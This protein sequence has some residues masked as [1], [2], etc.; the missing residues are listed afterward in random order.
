MFWFTAVSI[1]LLGLLAYGLFVEPRWLKVQRYR[2]SLHPHPSTWLRIAFLSDFHTGAGIPSS[3]WERIVLEVNALA[4]DAVILGGDFVVDRAVAIKEFLPFKK[5]NAPQGIYFVLGNHD[6]LERPQAIRTALIDMGFMD[7]T[8]RSI[9]LHREGKRVELHG[10]DDHWYGAPQPFTRES[11][12][13]PHILIAHEPD[14]M[15]DVK[16][17]ETDLVLA[18]HT[19]GRQVNVPFVSQW[20]IPA[21]LR[22]RAD[23]GRKMMNGVAYIVSRGLGQEAWRPRLA[24]RPEI[25]VVEIGV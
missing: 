21:K 24:S 16:E 17:G 2:E 7:L 5:L 10:L 4:P 11:K 1:A 15:L 8:N 3:W 9:P 6:F 12:N 25:V 13:V 14:V 19:H 18:G 23:G 20:W 22:G